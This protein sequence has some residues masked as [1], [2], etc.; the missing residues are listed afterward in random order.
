MTDVRK[1]EL[2]AKASDAGWKAMNVI[3]DECVKLIE[4]EDLPNEDAEAVIEFY[5]IPL[6][7]ITKLIT[8]DMICRKINEK[9]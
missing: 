4:D 3:I 1:K 9:R 6:S 7:G 8:R 5:L 2:I